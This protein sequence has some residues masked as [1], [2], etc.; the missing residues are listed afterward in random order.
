MEQALDL[1][2]KPTTP[3]ELFAIADKK[4]NIFTYPEITR[5][6]SYKDL[7]KYGNSPI[8]MIDDG[9]PFDDRFCIILYL[10]GEKTGHWTCLANNRYGINFLDSYGDVIDDQLKHVDQN[11]IGQNK[12]Y[13][14]DLLAKSKKTIYYNDLQLQRLN[15]NI[16][17]CGRYCALY[18]K[19]NYM[20]VDDFIKK[21]LIK[22]KEYNISPDLTVCILTAQ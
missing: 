21:L 5:F 12:K 19:Y 9:L 15:E 3:Y 17:T 7:F 1:L 16:A 4:C 10:T 14:I 18:F 6:K 2:N 20:N 22:A 11:I 13:L 8:P